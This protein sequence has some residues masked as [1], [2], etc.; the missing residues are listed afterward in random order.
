MDFVTAIQPWTAAKIAE[1]LGC[2]ERIVYAWKKGERQPRPWIQR[3]I[4]ERLKRVKPD[5]SAD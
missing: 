5:A 1:T 4:L 3:L 2:P